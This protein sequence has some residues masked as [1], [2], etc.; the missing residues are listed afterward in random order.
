MEIKRSYR[1][2]GAP[3]FQVALYL[4]NANSIR[5]YTKPEYHPEQ[6][7]VLVEEGM[8]VMQLD[9]D[10]KTFHKG[11]IY[12]IPANAVHCYRVCSDDGVTL[13]LVFDVSAITMQPDHYFQNNFTKPLEEGRLQLPAQ[14]LECAG[15]DDAAAGLPLPSTPYA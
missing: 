11:D 3:D 2:R 9:G 5:K 6:E 15:S 14:R 12:A 1:R 7:I 13:S 10:T 4:S 8:V